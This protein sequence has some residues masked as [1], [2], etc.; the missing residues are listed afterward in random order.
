MERS[1][2]S[3]GYGSRLTPVGRGAPVF[4]FNYFILGLTDIRAKLLPVRPHLN[5][6][7][8]SFAIEL[9]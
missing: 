9:R 2:V 1:R 3:N 7:N 5:I 6:S 8:Q 4:Q